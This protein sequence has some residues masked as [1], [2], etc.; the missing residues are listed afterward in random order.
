MNCFARIAGNASA[1]YRRLSADGE[2]TACFTGT[3]RIAQRL[4]QIASA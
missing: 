4:L 2:I 1:G 3:V